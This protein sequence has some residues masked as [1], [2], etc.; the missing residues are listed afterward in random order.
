MYIDS[1]AHAGQRGCFL[2]GNN[3]PDPDK[4]VLNLMYPR[5]VALHTPHLD[6]SA[7]NFSEENMAHTDGDEVSVLQ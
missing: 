4:H 1:H 3:I 6:I 7:C 5:F 2:F